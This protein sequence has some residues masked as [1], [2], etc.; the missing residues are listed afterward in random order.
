MTDIR[1]AWSEAF[2]DGVALA[3]P[4][5]LPG[6]VTT[7]WAYGDGR[8]HGVRVAIVDSGIEADHPAVGGVAGAVEVL[9]ADDDQDG[10]TAVEGPHED[11]YGH[12]T[13]CAGLVRAV[14]PEVELISVRVLGAG[15]RGS[16]DA[17]AGAIEWCIDHDVQIVNLSLS[18]RAQNVGR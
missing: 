18:T 7:E 6:V 5:V 1:P 13:A 4:L 8:G 11:L 3:P 17:F 15:L 10:V 9:V 2:L 16:A 12:G 14:A